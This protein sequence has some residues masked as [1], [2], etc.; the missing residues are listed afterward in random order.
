[1][2]LYL[3]EL[4]QGTI[5]REFM[6]WPIQGKSHK[7]DVEAMHEWLIKRVEYLDGIIKAYP[8]P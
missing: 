4:N 3:E 6:R 2:E 1:L 8:T 7:S 5:M